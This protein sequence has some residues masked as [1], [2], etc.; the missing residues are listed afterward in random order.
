MK[1]IIHFLV[2]ILMTGLASGGAF[3]ALTRTPETMFTLGNNS[4][5]PVLTFYTTGLATTPQIAFWHAVGTGR[6]LEKCNI[7][8]RLWKNLDD[9]RG[10]LLAGKG[11][12][13]LGHTDGF[14]QA[15]L[16]GA[17]VR[18]MI[19]TGWRKFYLVSTRATPP[20][21][22]AFY[23][24][25]LAFAPPGSPAIPILR[26][27]LDPDRPKIT[28]LS[29][30]PRQLAVK[31]IQGDISS[32]LVPEPLV[33]ILLEKV[34]GLKQGQ[35]LEDLYGRYTRGPA[36]MPIAGIAVNA[37]TADRYP[38]LIAFLAKEILASA[39]VLSNDPAQGIASL[40]AAFESFVPRDLIRK[41]L[42]R[43]LFLAKKSHEIRDEIRQYLCLSTGPGKEMALSDTIFWR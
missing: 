14:V 2:L 29:H 1:K 6:I 42:T 9:L 17:P 38:K 8:V 43:D 30:E 3:Q 26:H 19:T 39:L 25:S 13:W 34:P 35:S 4:D 22:N 37:A 16:R 24:N 11:D 36:R 12:L 28:F 27:I 15:A 21:F 33:T 20:R 31:L 18:L 5:L 41:S 7:K 32:A 10:T 23:G 40:P